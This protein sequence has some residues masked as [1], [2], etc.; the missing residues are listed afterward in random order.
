M[1]VGNQALFPDA[2][3]ERGLKHLHTL[4]RLKQNGLRAV[5]VYVVQ[6]MDV[7]IFDTAPDIDPAYAQ[8]LIDAVNA[9]VEVFPIRA[10]VTPEGIT[11]GELLPFAKCL[12]S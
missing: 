3:T 2:K 10:I 1:K 6:R 9:G 12:R 4:M 5:M 7:D 11:L 8:G